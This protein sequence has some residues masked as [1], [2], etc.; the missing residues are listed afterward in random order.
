MGLANYTD[1]L[2]DDV[3]Y[4]H[5]WKSVQVTLQYTLI[6]VPL[7]LGTAL[8]TGAADQRDPPGLQPVPAAAVPAGRDGRGGR[9]RHLAVAL[10][11]RSTALVNTMIGLV[12]IPPQQNWLN[13]PDLVIPALSFIAAWQ[14]GISMIIYLAGLKGIPRLDPRGPRS[15]TARAP[16]SGSGRSSC[17]CCGPPPSTCWSPA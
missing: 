17:R 15:S 16:S 6:A 1:L 4:P 5:F 10:R 12:G 9:G 11:T 7:T 13:T 14:C 8:V 2:F 3:K